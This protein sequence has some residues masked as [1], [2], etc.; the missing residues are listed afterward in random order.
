M[1]YEAKGQREKQLCKDP[2]FAA[3]PCPGV[4]ASIFVVTFD[5]FRFQ[6]ARLENSL[7]K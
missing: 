6:A 5:V 3:V 4:G 2:W 7:I 1:L